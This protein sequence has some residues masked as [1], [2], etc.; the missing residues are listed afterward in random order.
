MFLTVI[1]THWQTTAW[2]WFNSYYAILSC[3]KHISQI[4]ATFLLWFCCN[5]VKCFLHVWGHAV[6]D[7]RLIKSLFFTINSPTKP[8]AIQ[9]HTIEPNRSFACTLHIISNESIDRTVDNSKLLNSLLSHS[10]KLMQ[11]HKSWLQGKKKKRIS[12]LHIVV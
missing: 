2:C 8:S 10:P 1:K 9:L 11:T 4:L 5:R 3:F 7:I 6:E 12:C